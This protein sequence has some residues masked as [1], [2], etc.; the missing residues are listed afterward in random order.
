[1][2]IHKIKNILP[3]QVYLILKKIYHIFRFFN[4]VKIKYS[5]SKNIYFGS[6]KAAN[7]LKKKNIEFKTI[8]RIWFWKYNYF[9]YGKWY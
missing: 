8:F 2:K 1:M 5:S 7:F 9:C 6:N 4:L 3:N